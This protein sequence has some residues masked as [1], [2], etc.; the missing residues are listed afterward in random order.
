[1]TEV[2]EVDLLSPTQYLVM[3]V[4]AARWRCG[5]KS[6][7]FPVS[8]KRTLQKLNDNDWVWWTN[9]GSF[10]T[11]RLTGKGQRGMLHTNYTPPILY[12]RFYEEFCRAH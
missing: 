6:W 3:E 8:L 10:L 12:S 5:E 7:T 9:N 11:A 2:E 1:M 4:L